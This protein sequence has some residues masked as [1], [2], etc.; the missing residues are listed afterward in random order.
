[1]PIVIFTTLVVLLVAAAV[2]AVVLMG[3]RGHGREL[4]PEIADAM[5][6]TARHLNGEGQPPRQLV[7]LVDEA[8]DV[9]VPELR[10]LP[11]MARELPAK[12]RELPGKARDLAPLAREIPARAR[13]LPAKFRS[14]RSAATATSATSAS[15]C[16]DASDEA[17]QATGAS[18][19]AP[20]LPEDLFRDEHPEAHPGG[21]DAVEETRVHARASQAVRE[22]TPDQ[23]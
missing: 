3:I 8:K 7:A 2:I 13:E 16:D 17:T 1:M 18:V 20:D 19:W 14:L 21:V 11:A 6:R 12:A 5:A 15:R 10:D 9:Q 22:H 23:R 4:H